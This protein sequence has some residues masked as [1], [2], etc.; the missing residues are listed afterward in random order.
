MGDTHRI[1]G[2]VGQVGEDCGWPQVT[3]QVWG[4]AAQSANSSPCW[5]MAM[6]GHRR[7]IQP[8]SM[9]IMLRAGKDRQKILSQARSFCCWT[10]YV[11]VK[12]T[13]TAVCLM[14]EFH[15]ITQNY[16][17]LKK[18]YH[19]GFFALMV[20]DKI[21]TT[22]HPSATHP[23]T[24]TSLTSPQY[25][26]LQTHITHTT[27]ES[28]PSLHCR[29]SRMLLTFG[30]PHPH[31]GFPGGSAGKQSPHKAGDLD[32]IPGSRRS[33]REWNDNP[34]QYSCLENSMDWGAWWATVHG[35]TESDT[36][37]WLNHRHPHFRPVF[38]ISPYL[39][40]PTYPLRQPAHYLP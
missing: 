12:P 16:L 39:S 26:P 13:V 2:E 23:F 31:W 22:N 40:N 15:Q 24:I 19:P 14:A 10:V 6:G 38:V 1:Q 21:T 29:Q 7:K 8:Q 17:L 20:K 18:L 5:R 34:L 27:S 25:S 4:A 30:L 35:V 11:T 36:T 9:S 28:S 3:L 37:E 33:P 32:L